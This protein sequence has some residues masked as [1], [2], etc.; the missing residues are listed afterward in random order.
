MKKLLLSNFCLEF[1]SK[2]YTFLLVSNKDNIFYMCQVITKLSHKQ[3]VLNLFDLNEK[4]MTLF[5]VLPIRNFLEMQ[6]K[7]SVDMKSQI[8]SI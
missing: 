3:E 8:F 6:Q 1:P 5:S 2:Y 4:I 7:V